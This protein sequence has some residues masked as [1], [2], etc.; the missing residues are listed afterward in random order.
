MFC[1]SCGKPIAPDTAFCPHCGGCQAVD[2]QLPTMRVTPAAAAAAVQAA[3]MPP[4][5]RAAA[6]PAMAPAMAMPAAAAAAPRGARTAMM[7]GVAALV[8]ALLGGVGYWGWSNKVSGEETA[9]Q[10]AADEA[11]RA[12][13]AAEEGAQRLAAEEQRRL[14]AEQAARAAEATAAQAL[15]DRHIAAEEAQAQLTAKAGV[16]LTQ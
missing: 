11:A 9:R 8:V 5:P 12:R 10:L 1:S 15:L 14:A 13:Q 6:A 7:A 16:P 3:T 4:P 2:V